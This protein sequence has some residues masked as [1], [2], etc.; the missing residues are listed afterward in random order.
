MKRLWE[1]AFLVMIVP[2]IAQDQEPF[3]PHSMISAETQQL[4]VVVTTDWHQVPGRL[5]RFEREGKDH[6]WRPNGRAWPIVVGRHGLAWGIGEH[7]GPPKNAP[8]IKREGDGCAPA[9]GFA[10]MEAFGKASLRDVGIQHF[11]YRQM[12]PSMRG[13]DDP[14]SRYYNRIV[15]ELTAK[16]PD[17]QSAEM[18]WREDALY[19]LGIVV[20]H[21]W[22]PHPGRGSC[23]FM[24]TWRGL[25]IGTAGC[26][27]MTASRMETLA[28]WLIYE[29]K[30]LLV[31]LPAAEYE[32]YKESMKLPSLP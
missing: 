14:N 1:I 25:G 4:L 27:A 7:G 17:W 26:T 24:H 22:R 5:W 15:D 29:K 11:P 16:N 3:R 21:N 9:G 13:I 28:K 19:D 23:I 6:A 30:P 31:Q 20:G 8:Q 18:M 32:F 12:S 2:A 10:L